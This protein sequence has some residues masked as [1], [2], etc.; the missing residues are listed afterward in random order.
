VTLLQIIIDKTKSLIKVSK[1]R[2]TKKELKIL[3]ILVI[4]AAIFLMIYIILNNFIRKDAPFITCFENQRKIGIAVIMYTAE[5]D[6]IYPKNDLFE[7]INIDKIFLRCPLIK[8][9]IQ[10]SY[11]FNANL[12]GQSTKDIKEPENIVMLSDSNAKDN[13]MRSYRDMALRHSE[14]AIVIF[15]DGR[16]SRWGLNNADI[17]ELIFK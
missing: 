3:L 13:M 15:S 7:R 6:N 12:S 2:L 16:T 8:K 5:N 9:E 1:E 10:N 11:G 4:M 14:G 17:E